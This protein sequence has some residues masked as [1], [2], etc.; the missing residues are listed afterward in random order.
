MLALL[1]RLRAPRGLTAPAR[2]ATQ[3]EA[4]QALACWPLQPC[5]HGEAGVAAT[6]RILPLALEPLLHRPAAPSVAPTAAAAETETEAEAEAA[7]A[8]AAEAEEEAEAD[9]TGVVRDDKAKRGGN[10]RVTKAGKGGELDTG[11]GE[12]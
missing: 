3:L 4:V 7:E 9:K 1:Q 10:S 2:R 8:E 5:A 6:L 11:E 12:G